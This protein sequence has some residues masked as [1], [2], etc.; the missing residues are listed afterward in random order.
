MPER[1]RLFLIDGHALAYRSYF[2]FIRSPLINSKGQNTSAIYGFAS[3]VLR[4]IERESPDRIA[5][6]FDSPEPTFRHERFA[7]YKATREKMPDDMRDQLPLID[8]VAA[9]L[10]LPILR[11]PGYEADDVIGTIARRAEHAG[12]DALIVSGDKDFTQLVSDHVKLLDLKKK[13]GEDELIDRAAVEARF[14]VPPEK[15]IDVLGLMGDASDN[16]PGVQGVGEKTAVELVRTFGSLEAAL[17]HAA[18]VKNKRVREGL[19]AGRDQALLSRELVTIRTDAPVGFDP[20]QFGRHTPDAP[21]LI[22]LFEQL[23]FPSL[24]EKVRFTGPARSEAEGAAPADK[25]VYHTVS[26][27]GAF[28]ALLARLRAAEEFVLDTETTSSEPTCA[29]IVGLSFA[30]REREAFYVPAYDC[31]LRIADCG[32]EARRPQSDSDLPLFSGGAAS[33]YPQ[34]RTPNTEH[35][36]RAVLD[37]LRPILEDPRIRKGGQN[38]KYDAVVLANYGIEVRGIGFD[39]MVESYL[40]DP[41]QRQHNLD[42]LALKHLNFQKIPTSALIGKGKTQISMADV[43]V[44]EVAPYACEDADVTLR[45]HRLFEPKLEELGLKRLYEEV[46]VPLVS[47][48][49]RMESIGVRVNLGLLAALSAEFAAKIDA[50]GAEIHK[51]AGEEFNINSTQ[52]LGAILFE[53]LQIQKGRGGRVRKTKTGFA[54]S[55]D[56]LEDFAEE[57]IVK[58]ILEY[59]GL[60]KLKGTYVDAFPELVNPRTGKIHTSFN[61]TVTATGRLSSSEPNLQNIPI[62][63]ELGKKIREAFVPSDPSRVLVCADYSQIELRILAHYTGDPNLIAAFGRGEDIHRRTASEVFEVPIE[64][65]TPEM[66][67][68]SKAINFGIIY[69]MGPQRLAHDTGISLEDAQEFIA[70]YFRRYP[71]IKKF[72]ED[73]IAAAERDGFVTTLLGRR[74]PIPEISSDNQGTRSAAERAA[75]NTPIQGSAAD[76]IKVAMVRLDPRL[77]ASHPD[78]WMILQVHDELVFD[79]PAGEAEAVARAVREEME[80]AMELKVPVKVD[81]AIG[82][83]WAK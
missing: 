58:L 28:G 53:K 49:A 56:A 60:A 78:A 1:P 20:Q 36:L 46:E 54:T 67:A 59:R 32:L 69:G 73:T 79:V 80:G 2:A 68:R 64:A 55:V 75:V 37:R 23:E 9:A 82:T 63:T 51:L 81:V 42:L 45:L 22:Q 66:R 74:R 40:L 47:I 44:A 77:R 71:L 35:R 41:A 21:R 7:D 18:E 15:V 57:P 11:C 62:R 30:F 83:T 52:Q 72:T 29:E 50:L 19:L 48:L 25:V 10:G 16:V 31:G 13:G 8:E 43:P 5:V 17:E 3:A 12:W 33:S 76:L 39:T 61:Q 38:I 70:R 26:D 6:V 27:E 24:I 65:V 34:H 4:L 14:G